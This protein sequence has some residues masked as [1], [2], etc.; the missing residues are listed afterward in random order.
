[1]GH[2]VPW[3]WAWDSL[4]HL[5]LAQNVITALCGRYDLRCGTKLQWM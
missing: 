4:S 5:R 1:M 2:S 3:G